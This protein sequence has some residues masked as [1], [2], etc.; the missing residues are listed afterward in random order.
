MI[1]LHV[2][3]QTYDY[4]CGAMALQLVMAYYGVDIRG[5]SLMEA[6]GTGPDG[7]RVN[8]MAAVA[9]QHGFNVTAKTDWTLSELRETVDKGYP[10]I[11][12]VQAWADRFLTLEEWRRD[13]DDGHYVVVIGHAQGV[14]LFEDPATFRRTWLREREFL[15]RWHDRDAIT[16]EVHKHFG[17]VLKGKEPAGIQYEHMN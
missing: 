11:V 9:R 5:D 7:T 13:Y 1:N 16:G 15:A 6:L 10:V 12:L 17:M 14:L 2:G 4:D 8:K 3:R